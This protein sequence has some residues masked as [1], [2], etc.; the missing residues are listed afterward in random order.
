V[1]EE[2]GEGQ[3]ADVHSGTHD[4]F[5]SYASQDAGVATAVVAALERN[6]IACWIAPRDV[7]PGTFYGDEIVH[8]I[9]A[10]KTSVLILSQNAAASQ[11]VLREV[12]RAA[13]KRH[14]V[15]SLRIDNAQLPAG[16]EY[17]LNTS[18]WLDASGVDATRMI[19]KL[20]T[21]VR[22]GIVK[23]ATPDAGFAA[24]PPRLSA[25]AGS[26]RSLRPTAILAGSLVFVAIAG[27]AAYR[28]WLPA[29]QAAATPA[30]TATAT[31]PAALPAT[32]A[33]PEKSVAVL[34]FADMSEKKDQEYFSEGLSE[35]LINLLSQVSALRVPARTSSFYFKDKSEDI[36][37]IARRLLVAHVLEG[38]VRKSG[39]FL[40]VTVQLV[41][42]DNG[43]HLWSQTYDRKL[44]DIFKVQD[45]IAGAV[46]KAL[47]VS[48]LG[49][50]A[51]QAIPTASSE[52]YTLY[53]QA[54]SMYQHGSTHADDER[55]F[56]YLRRA[57][58]LDPGFARAWAALAFFRC[59]D[60]SYFDFNLDPQGRAEAHDAAAR[61]LELDP[62]L[63]DAH[64]AM[65]RFLFQVEWDWKASESEL[66]HALELDPVNGDAL[67][68]LSDLLSS[69]DSHSTEAL[70][71]AKRAVFRDPLYSI[72][73]MQLALVYLRD[74][75]FVAAEDASRKALD[76][77][78]TAELLPSMLAS[79]L[80]YRGD[81]ARALA[82]LEREPSERYR[83]SL[84]PLI[85]D[86]LGRTRE[87]DRA[88]GTYVAKYGDIAPYSIASVYA[89][90]KDLDRAFR[91]LDRAYR[92]REFLL[93][94]LRSDP[95]FINLRS[96]SRYYA[97]LRKM[98]IPE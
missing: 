98:K 58:K 35:E 41:R 63:S 31:T 97:L 25:P 76:L 14:A 88:L 65:G 73:Y 45:E 93:V 17:F 48:L 81:P 33:I 27:F 37:T 28:L 34:P 78:P 82:E 91:W 75:K 20:V 5:I 62:Q 43:Y 19:P 1:A 36:P 12:E 94:Y 92:Q 49:T 30:P 10:A 44:D 54:R 95:D 6:G 7:T 67:I 40:R 55:A 50:E 80:I 64:A 51:P 42:A 61:A 13:S 52:A 72:N 83:E 11:H 9:D 70:V 8:A 39:N 60:A 59:G 89:G 57:V 79:V 56:A 16:L 29:R 46:V 86:R 87:A 32:L 84:R 74:G 68:D 23:T 96:D 77:A 47:K 69:L 24:A 90:R 38:S 22:L 71:L 3:A 21:A 2:D 85:L 26:M 15:I 53:L 66:R 18:Q 4:V